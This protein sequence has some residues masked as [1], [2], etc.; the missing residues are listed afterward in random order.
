[1][2]DE[3]P[4]YNKPLPDLRPED[5]TFW[6][7]MKEHRFILPCEAATGKP[8]WY[9]R[10]YAPGTLGETS[11]M[12]ASGE[13]T[14]YTYSTHF[15]GPSKSYKGDPPHIVA[16]IDLAEGPRMMSIL[17]KDEAGFPSL[18]AEDV[19]I[20]MKVKIV[21]DDVTDEI[22]MPKFTPAG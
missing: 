3:K 19:T 4:A 22:T 9:P 18:D 11:W 14:V 17:V 2:A 5:K 8:F 7:A 16:L 12:D 21:F 10:K 1:M 20:G 13:G 15:I 6:D